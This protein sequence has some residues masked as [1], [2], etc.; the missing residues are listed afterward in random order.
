MLDAPY[1]GVL[2]VAKFRAQAKLLCEAAAFD[3][4]VQFRGDNLRNGGQLFI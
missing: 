1:K 3:G 2:R 4:L